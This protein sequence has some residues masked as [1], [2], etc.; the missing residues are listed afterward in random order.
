MVDVPEGHPLLP[1]H[2]LCLDGFT[3]AVNVV[4]DID[5]DPARHVGVSALVLLHV[6][7]DRA[8]H[9]SCIQVRWDLVGRAPC[10]V[11]QE[12]WTFRMSQSAPVHRAILIASF[13]PLCWL[14]MMA[15]HELGHVIGA[16]GTGGTVAKVV[17][18]PFAISR[19]DVDPNPEPLLVAWLGALVGVLFPVIGWF[20]LRSVTKKPWWLLRFFA[21]FCC[22][23]NGAY[24]GVG[25][26][27]GVGDAGD[28]M[29]YGA[30]AWMLVTFGVIAIPV[31]IW[32]WH[33]T[34]KRFGLGMES[35]QVSRATA[36]SSVGV[37]AAAVSAGMMFSDRM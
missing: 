36:F 34:G 30:P 8:V 1:D 22:V 5:H 9:R 31:G 27:N 24:L 19:T 26:F 20:I 28:L 33:G 3:P 17:L 14:G 7:R 32:L 25:A 15:V 37:L 16:S 10:H 12:R 2:R 4:H 13:L 35:A 18:H 21:G 23:A 29:R 6:L 11:A